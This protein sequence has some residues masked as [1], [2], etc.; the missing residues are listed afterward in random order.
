MAKTKKKSGPNVHEFFE[1]IR[2]VSVEKKLSFEDMLEMVEES[3][4]A[5]YQRKFSMYADLKV[6]INPETEEMAVIHKRKVVEKVRIPGTEISVSDAQKI[7]SD[8]QLDQMVEERYN[9]LTFSR[10]VANNICYLLMQRLRN[11]ERQVIYDEFKS[12]V[13]DLINGYFLRW[14]DREV[15]YVD[16]G[17]T[18]GILPRREQIP[19]ER[20]RPG[21]RV[22]ALIKSVELGRERLN[23]PGPVIILSRS[24]PD[25]VRKLFEMEIPEIYDGTVEIIDIVRHAG[26]RTKLLVRSMRQDVDPVGACVGIKGVRIQSIVRELGNERIDIVNFS[27]ETQELIVSALSP[28]EVVEIRVDSST[29]EAFVVV[30]DKSYSVAIGNSGHN[31]R[32]A[33]QITGYNITVKSQEQFNEDMAS[34]EAKVQLEALF[35]STEESEETEEYTSL[36]E[37]PGI[38]GRII[39]LLQDGGIKSIEE[40]LELSEDNLANMSGIGKTTA[41]QI[42]RILSETVEFED[43]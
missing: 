18:E 43:A 20:F 21:D 31:V 33:C 42:R 16:M 29:K 6:I 34:P 40:L 9:P 27:Q 37:L 39:G 26:Y 13:G 3:F 12:K 30:S 38:T 28:A 4:L 7:Q 5:A 32:L 1:F 15:V 17:R 8:A 10:A 23:E 35:Q 19:G 24:S 36:N 25:F 11:V 2:E 22:K 14:R 41:K